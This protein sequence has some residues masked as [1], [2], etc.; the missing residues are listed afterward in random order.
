MPAPRTPRIKV[1]RPY[2]GFLP[3]FA[4]DALDEPAHRTQGRAYIAAPTKV[5]ALGHAA[6]ANLSTTASEY[7]VAAGDQFDALLAAGLLAT[8]GEIIATR[9]QDTSDSPVVRYDHDTDTWTVIGHFTRS[10]PRTGRVDG[11]ALTTTTDQD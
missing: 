11:V 4:L 9:S 10:N 6:K 1:Y 7:R 8:D 2:W 3:T 5:A